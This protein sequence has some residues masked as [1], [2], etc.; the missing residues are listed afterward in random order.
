MIWGTEINSSP[1]EWAS[2]KF[3]FLGL[4]LRPIRS[5]HHTWKLSGSCMLKL[6]L[7][8]Y[9]IK[10]INALLGRFFISETI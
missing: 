8:F 6:E 4:Q 9:D 1:K 5:T 2:W 3:H 10:S 7:G